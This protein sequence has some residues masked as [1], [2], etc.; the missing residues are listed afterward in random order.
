M[1]RYSSLRRRASS[2]EGV[3]VELINNEVHAAAF[4]GL[5][6]G[7]V[8]AV[9]GALLDAPAFSEPDEPLV[10]A[11][12]MS[13]SQGADGIVASKD[14]QS[15]ADLEGK[16]VAVLRGGVQQFYLSV[17]L[18]EAGLIEADI[19]VV[20]LTPE[21]A[22]QAFLLQEVDAAVTSDPFLTE[23]ANAGHGHLLTDTSEQP[24]LIVDCLLVKAD[25]FDD[26]K[27]DFRALARTWDA[28]VRYVEDHPDDAN[29][30][31]ARHLGGG[32]EILRPSARSWSAWDFY[33]AD[34]NRQYFGTREKPGQAYGTMQKAIDVWS[35]LGMLKVEV[36]P[37]DVI[38]HG[39]FDE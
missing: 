19:E 35:E 27:N 3:E 2:K 11:L 23:A 39:I 9:A 18:K 38:A 12:V 20:D 6:A 13:D 32:L 22:G 25:V 26:R 8:D 14:V 31:M 36:T 17:L 10:C 30:I 33:D 28:A 37:A 1:G 5:F 34:R 16:S 15:I 7:Q 29:E 21:D 24:G 4:G